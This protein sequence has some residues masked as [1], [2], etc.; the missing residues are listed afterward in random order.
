MAA[1][2]EFKDE[3]ES[4]KNKPLK[5]RIAYF[6]D[7][8]KW[9]V[10]GGIAAVIVI[11]STIKGI[12]TAKDTAVYAAMINY[13]ENVDYSD[14]VF[15]DFLK[16]NDVDPKKN[17]IN[18]DTT[19]YLTESGWSPADVQS[20]QKLSVL[21]AAGDLDSIV[22][23]A[24]YFQKY[25]Y[26]GYL[27]DLRDVCDEDELKSIE[28]DI[29]YIDGAISKLVIEAMD[30]NK[31]YDLSEAPDPSKPEEMEDPI[32]VGIR[33]TDSKLL[34]AHFEYSYPAEERYGSVVI[35]SKRPGMTKDML[36]YLYKY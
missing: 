33:L 10:I 29:Y 24:P 28:G 3:R 2:D 22:T 27:T 18:L 26:Q 6:W 31:E 17:M 36:M 9:Y 1:M 34:D 5:Y 11:V 23:G 16:M 4:V 7:Y 30:D 12:V 20:V 32:P 15:E 35:N 14:D 25:A 19:L 13:T 8:Y 21:L